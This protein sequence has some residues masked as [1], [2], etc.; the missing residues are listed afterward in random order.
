MNPDRTWAQCVAIVDQIMVASRSLSLVH[1][2]TQRLCRIVL[3]SSVHLRRRYP[4]IKRDSYFTSY[5]H[6]FKEVLTELLRHVLEDVIGA[7]ADDVRCFEVSPTPSPTF[8]T[9]I[10]RFGKPSPQTSCRDSRD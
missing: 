7:G 9:P 3:C 5:L 1:A 10:R 8:S 6:L 4:T 2:P